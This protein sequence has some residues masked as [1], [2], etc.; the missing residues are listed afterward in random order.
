MIGDDTFEHRFLEDA[1][2][3]ALK[4]IERVRRHRIAPGRSFLRRVDTCDSLARGFLNL[5]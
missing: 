5:L 3:L 2:E 4:L 1:I